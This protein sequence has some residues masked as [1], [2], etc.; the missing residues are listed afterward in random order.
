LTWRLAILA[1]TAV[2]VGIAA[3]AQAFEWSEPA[4]WV[5]DLVTGWIL[6]ACGL[7][8]WSARP[9]SRSSLLMTLTG[10]AWFAGNFAAGAAYLHRGPLVHLL[11]TFPRGRTTG[12]LE[13]VAVV[14]GYGA[15]VVAAVWRTELVA[16]VG[17]AALV[18]VAWR[19]YSRALGRERRARRYSL[20]ATAAAGGVIAA[21]AV[22]R[23]AFP[24]P[25]ATDATL[26]AYEATLCALA[27]G[28]LAALVR[29][30]WE[31]APV[32]DLVVDLGDLRS[33]TLRD[34]L[35]RALGDPTL[36][37][38][39][40]V[41]D[42]YV[43]A[44]GR[45][46]A[47]PPAGSR[48]R[49]TDIHRDG[50]IVATLVHDPAVLGDRGLE[51]AIGAAAGLAA[52]NARLQAEVR[53]QLADLGASRSRLLHA[54]DE[55]RR[56]L[57]QRL[58]ATAERRLSSLLPRLDG[59]PEV[60]RIR[61]QL[62]RTLDDLH[63]LAAGL[64]PRALTEGGLAAAL[65]TLAER[66]PVPVR[67]D[68]PAR[69]FGAEAETAAYYVC[70]EALANIAKYAG[71]TGVD[72]VVSEGANAL[73]VVVTDDGVGG[74]DPARG[75]G[76]RGLADRVEAAGGTLVVDSPPGRGTRLTASLPLTGSPA[77]AA[78][79]AATAPTP[80]RTGHPG[81][82]ASPARGPSIRRDGAGT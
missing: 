24:T 80:T 67:I 60:R 12:R 11:L 13:R 74:A 71:A 61:E 45:P 21:A 57:E 69:R 42:E 31:R 51:E 43:D 58:S 82:S 79:L 16:I 28:L 32:T 18:A 2:A 44:A 33:G 46:V 30:P 75:T 70:S 36:E 34:A 59:A 50:Q 53:A 10:F 56:R 22:V 65:S 68:A 48:R 37:V 76:L 14:A 23:L 72:I 77:P 3:E 73:R 52:S 27:V 1:A 9:R 35:A 39:Y 63:E 26:L 5:P 17:A 54:G 47:L 20:V 81:P 29:E 55:E 40:R 8:G 64:H 6:I 49:T 78:P 7:A 19:S 4:R 66:S 38:A 25:T 15:A 41:A 62:A